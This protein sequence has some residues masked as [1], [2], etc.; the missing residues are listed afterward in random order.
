MIS[1]YAWTV[2]A[3]GH[4]GVPTQ[5]PENVAKRGQE[6]PLCYCPHHNWSHPRDSQFVIILRLGGVVEPVL[7]PPDTFWLGY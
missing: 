1:S 2:T 5:F 7:A 3:G 4:P 6:Y